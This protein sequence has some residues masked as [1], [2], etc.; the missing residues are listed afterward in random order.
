MPFSRSESAGTGEVA[1]WAGS[2]QPK[3]T[4]QEDTIMK[5]IIAALIATAFASGVAF[6][7]DKK[8]EKKADAKPAAAAPAKKEEAKP[9]AAAPAKKEEAKPAAAAPAKKEEAKPA[10]APAKK[11]EAPKK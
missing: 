7:Q 3:T 5:K 10:A 6:A 2:N 9:A 4:F 8:D 11:E 1:V